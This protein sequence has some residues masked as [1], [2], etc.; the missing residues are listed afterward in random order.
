MG[1]VLVNNPAVEIRGGKNL[2]CTLTFTIIFFPNNL[3]PTYLDRYSS[4]KI[5][6]HGLNENITSRC[7]GDVHTPGGGGGGPLIRA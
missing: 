7:L 3:I 1:T 4:K 2:E 6:G 5:P